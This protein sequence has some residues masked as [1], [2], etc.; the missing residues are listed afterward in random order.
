[1]KRI[2]FFPD[3]QSGLFS[4]GLE[5]T[6]MGIEKL[7][8]LFVLLGLF[9]L[10]SLS[11]GCGSGGGDSGETPGPPAPAGLSGTV[12]GAGGSPVSG[13]MVSAFSKPKTTTAGADG[14]FSFPTITTG[15]HGLVVSKPGYVD[16]Y[17]VG[18]PTKPLNILLQN[19][20]V[21]TSSVIAA[22]GGVVKSNA[23]NN[24]T[25]F[26][27]IPA[28]GSGTFTV[29]GSPVA[30]AG[31]SVEY[32]DIH[33]PIPVPLPCVETRSA[34]LNTLIGVD[35]QAPSVLVSIKPGLLQL[36][37]AAALNLPNPDSMP[38]TTRILYFDVSKRLWEDTGETVAGLPITVTRGGVYG[39]F[40]EE[41]KTSAIRGAGQ[42]GSI[43]F[44]SDQAVEIGEDGSYYIENVIIPA[45]GNSLRVEMF[46]PE[47]DSSFK[48][49]RSYVKPVAGAITDVQPAE[50]GGALTITASPTRIVADGLSSSEITATL[51]D[52]GGFPIGGVPVAF[53]KELA[54]LPANNTFAGTGITKT[55]P[56]YAQKGVV[57]FSMTHEGESNFIVWLWEETE[58]KIALLANEIG[59]LEQ[60]STVENLDV[61]NYFL[62][63]NADGDW[64]V[65]IEGNIDAVPAQ[66]I[67]SVYTDAAGEAS[68]RYAS[69][70]SKGFVT[71]VAE[72]DA[73]SAETGI[74][75]TAGPPANVEL[76]SVP[77]ETYAN[78]ADTAVLK[79]LVTDIENNPVEDG[80]DVVFSATLGSVPVKTGTKNGIATV[81]VTSVP[82][83]VTVASTITATVNGEADTI[84]VDF[85]GVSLIDMN[86]AP[87]AILADGVSR[88]TITVRLKD[89]EGVAVKDQ[90]VKFTTNSGTLVSASAQTNDSGVALVEIIAPASA[91]TATVTAKYG[92]ITATTEI[93]FQVSSVVVGGISVSTGTAVLVADGESTAAIRAAVVDESGAPVPGIT[94]AFTTTAGSFDGTDATTKLT[95]TSGVAEVILTS[96]TKLG[97]AAIVA[98]ASGF[99]ATTSVMFVAGA[100]AN[101]KVSASPGNLTAD[102]TSTSKIAATV[103]D[104]NNN[105]VTDGS[106]VTFAADHGTLDRLTGVTSGGVADAIYTS[107]SSW[108]EAGR[109]RMTVT[110]T[111]GKEGSTDITLIEVQIAGISLTVNPP[112]IAQG[113]NDQSTITASVTVAGGGPAPDG[114]KVTFS[115][116]RGDGQIDPSATTSAGFAIATLTSGNA[117]SA[118]VRAEAGGRYAEIEVAYTPGSVTVS[119]VPNAVLGTGVETAMVTALVESA[120][121][122]PCTGAGVKFELSGQSL[123][124]IG[125]ATETSEPGQYTATFSAAA[126]GGTA[127]ITATATIDGTDVSGSDTVQIQPPPG[128]LPARWFLVSRIWRGIWWRTATESIFAF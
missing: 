64:T 114:T 111:N 3:T 26:L 128:I 27:T 85:T 54:G 117:E 46:Y 124:T 127:T 76:M 87:A 32:L 97:Q 116:V 99:K 68:F 55:S 110:A 53:T 123:G 121:G 14:K 83:A 112:A 73:L 25:A 69:S 120:D 104:K 89:V 31:I 106:T 13:A 107:P 49:S 57:T 19:S 51:K 84:H 29:G 119:I 93:V 58:G 20:S 74:T 44:V 35:I 59:T 90:T 40:F 118:I 65:N 96:G 88:S 126:K 22:A 91:G 50:T 23:I 48:R 28:Q 72:F 11:A 95:T 39:F 41:D 122:N 38:G 86:A 15:L 103:R 10:L 34:D 66:R 62:Q 115:I 125:D 81:A 92:L 70:T 33:N 52:D 8:C 102:G 80:T 36:G 37:D 56:F 21:S 109:A 98:S 9:C 75:Q 101:I 71:I 67:G 16:S 108:P 79:A 105:P 12:L 30:T 45:D 60:Y 43:I 6:V 100:P 94:V 113:G 78:G 7:R 18:D 42:P 4:S 63:V 47:E 5:G 82:S 61:G 24:D 1:M 77:G 17:R 2:M